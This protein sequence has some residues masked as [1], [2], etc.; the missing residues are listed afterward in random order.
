MKPIRVEMNVYRLLGLF[1]LMTSFIFINL[2]EMATAE[3]K[4]LK[5]GAIEPLSGSAAL[6]GQAMNQGVKLAADEF[7]AKGGLK[8]G[9]IQY[10]VEVVEEDDKYSGTGGASAAS[11][12]VYQEGIR[13]LTGS[14]ASASVLAMQPITEKNNCLLLTN[15]FADVLGKEKPYTFRIAPN[16]LQGVA[17]CFIAV[18]QKYPG[19]VKRIAT[20][21]ANDATGWAS[22]NAAKVAAKALGWEF[23]AEEYYER[24]VTDFHPLLGKVLPRNLTL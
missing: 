9:S 5:W 24:G 3:E 21:E 1:V 2:V 20:I 23:V 8:V 10:K 12:L 15:A 18:N 17:G 4:I 14:L 7:N 6:W 22:A 16:V 11:K 19:Q 13:F